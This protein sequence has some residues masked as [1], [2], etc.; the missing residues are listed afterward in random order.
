MCTDP[1][2]CS[3]DWKLKTTLIAGCTVAFLL[4]LTLIVGVVV[5]Y[6]KRKDNLLQGKRDRME[7]EVHDMDTRVNWN[8]EVAELHMA[9]DI[10][11]RVE[12]TTI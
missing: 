9:S 8:N 3:S 10:V 7:R 5:C 2:I 11:I 6:C 1:G 12:S 4:P